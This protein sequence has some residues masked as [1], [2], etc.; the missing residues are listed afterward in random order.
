MPINTSD[1]FNHGLHFIDWIILIAYAMGMIGIG[2]YY[3]RKKSDSADYFLGNGQ[4]SSWVTGISLFATLFS[5]ISYLSIPGEMIKHGPVFLINFLGIPLAYLVV[6]YI[7][8]PA[9]MRHRVISA[10]ELL[11]ERL[12]S[13][14]RTLGACLFII[15]RLTWMAVL[16]FMSATAIAIIIGLSPDDITLVLIITGFISVIYTMLGGLRAVMISDVSQALILAAGAFATLGIIT[17]RLGGFSWF[18]TT[19]NPLWEE[20]PLFSWDPHVRVSIVGI[21]IMNFFWQLCSAGGDQTAIQRYMSTRDSKSASRAYLINSCAAIFVCLLVATLG[22]ALLSYYTHFS[23]LLPRSL[24]TGNGADQLFPLFIAHEL[25]VGVCGLVVAALFAAAMS[26]IDSGVNSI[27]AVISRDFLE[28]GQTAP[29][30]PHTQLR[31]LRMLSFVIGA[32]SILLATQVA[33]VP[34]SLL[35][36]TTKTTNL[37]AGPIFGLFILA[38]FTKRADAFGAWIGT[39]YGCVIALTIAFWDV[40]TGD[41]PLSFMWIIPPSLICQ[42]LIGLGLSGLHLTTPIKRAST[43]VAALAPLLLAVYFCLNLFR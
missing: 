22:F 26:S 23:Q 37:L 25:P 32:L 28:R 31:R 34:G 18:P 40:L 8:I 10:Y 19:W 14:V 13:S 11:E 9:Y 2:Y 43:A 35:E 3:S 4:M 33:H 42:L 17:W 20:Q 29:V 24:T 38:I 27:S 30:P 12:G 21:I 1:L 36:V 41:I 39:T 16:H 6:G 5:T 7:L 15:L